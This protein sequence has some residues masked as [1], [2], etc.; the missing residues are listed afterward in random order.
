MPQYADAAGTTSF[1]GSRIVL[2][3]TVSWLEGPQ[4]AGLEH[5]ELEE[6]VEARTRKLARLLLQ[7]QQDVREARERRLPQVTGRAGALR[8]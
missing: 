7:E 6:Q 1:A 8:R 5:G 4:A 3:E 2:E